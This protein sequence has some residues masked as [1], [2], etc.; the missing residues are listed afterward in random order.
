[1]RVTH[2]MLILAAAVTGL[3]S[4]LAAPAAGRPAAG[5]VAGMTTAGRSTLWAATYHGPQSGESL[6]KAEAVS[7][8]GAMLFVT[9][10]TGASPTAAPHHWATV[11]YNAATGTQ[12][13]AQT[14]QGTDTTQAGSAAASA[15]AV[16]PDG[17]TVFVS[18]YVTNTGGVSAEATIAYSAATGARLWVSEAP[19]DFPQSIAVS[20]DGATL[21]VMNHTYSALA[22]DT[23]TGHLQW[24][25]TPAGL[26]MDS[27]AQDAV[28]SPDGSTVFI[29]GY[30]VDSSLHEVYQ[31]AAFDTATGAVEWL[32]QYARG[33]TDEVASSI[34]VSPDSA[35]VFIAGHSTADNR[36]R[37][38]T[39][40]DSSATGAVRWTRFSAAVPGPDAVSPDGS[41][42]FV[43]GARQAPN[44]ETVF[45]TQ[46]RDVVTGALLWTH[47]QTS[48]PATAPALSFD[49]AMTVSPAGSAVFITGGISNNTTGA[50]SFVTIAYNPAT[51]AQLWWARYALPTTGIT[52][53]IPAA[54]VVS[55]DGS[56]VFVTGEGQNAAGTVNFATVAYRA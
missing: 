56:K 29:T 10:S 53:S 38:I 48:K 21:F 52:G 46:A 5:T 42:L 55:P 49:L 26:D 37:Q 31:T 19:D 28:M 43:G 23:A 20:P 2:R 51:G 35:T 6:A 32:Q 34:A 4:I 9:G 30:A 16:S 18:G 8:G 33:G 24:A 41:T 25:A 45:E 14:F 17:S 47:L 12:Q 3:I 54:I 1:M 27:T 11:A 44:G 50:Y 36:Y 15:I 7:P 13:W 39:L 22:Y 40:A